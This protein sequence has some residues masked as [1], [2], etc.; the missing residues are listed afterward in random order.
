[1]ATDIAEVIGGAVALNLLF[2][3]PLLWGGV[4]TGTVSLD[5]A[6]RAVPARARA[7]SSSSSSASSRSSRSASPFGV[8][9]GPPDPAG[10]IGGLVPRFEGTGSVLLA[11]S[12]LGATIMPHA[13]YA[14]S[15]A[16]PRPLRA[17]ERPRE[18][19]VASHRHP[20]D[21]RSDLPAARDPLGRHRSRCSSPAR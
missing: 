10:V 20:A 19:T 3:L 7:R 21:A 11:A 17:G 12:I 9:V 14:H 5:A 15:R 13:I 1:M 8:F 2:G 4:I 16:R 6:R 18:R